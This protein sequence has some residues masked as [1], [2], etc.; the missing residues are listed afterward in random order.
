MTSGLEDVVAA[1]TRLSH[2]DGEAGRLV[3]AGYAVEELA[4]NVVVRRDGV[5][6]AL[7]PSAGP[8]RAA[9]VSRASRVAA[10][11]AAGGATGPRG[12]CA[13]HRRRPWMRCAWR[14]PLLS[15]GR[16]ENPLEDGIAAIAAFPT[17]VGIVLAPAARAVAGRSADRSRARRALPAPAVRR[18][19]VGRAGACRSRPISTPSAT[20]ASMPRRSRRVSSCRR[21]RM[22]SRRSPAQS[23]R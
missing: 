23:V 17:I 7:W 9:A 1:T 3:I 4:P 15:L 13:R 19:T 22:S 8:G 16:E 18:G 14:R 6:A 20:T 12:S 10:S 5:P 2:V 21:G 11:A